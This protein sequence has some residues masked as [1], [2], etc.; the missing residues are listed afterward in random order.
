LFVRSPRSTRTS[1]KHQD[2]QQPPRSVSQRVL[3]SEQVTQQH[4]LQRG[5]K[6]TERSPHTTIIKAARNATPKPQDNS[7]K[8]NR[9]RPRPAEA[10]AGGE[11]EEHKPQAKQQEGAS[12]VQRQ[13]NFASPTALSSS[14]A[15]TKDFW[16][17]LHLAIVREDLETFSSLLEEHPKLVFKPSKVRPLLPFA[18]SSPSSTFQP[19]FV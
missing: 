12:K 9:S 13:R 17:R 1:I 6:Q 11:A 14:T 18:L 19:P 5:T 3:H 15:M 16:T 4:V 10:E 8:T 2:R 7:N